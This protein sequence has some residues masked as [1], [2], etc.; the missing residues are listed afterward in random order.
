MNETK[1]INNMKDID[2]KMPDSETMRNITNESTAM[3][4]EILSKYI[5]NFSQADIAAA[6]TF[7]MTCLI[8]AVDD[9]KKQYEM[10]D[11][12][13]LSTQKILDKINETKKY[14]D[15]EALEKIMGRVKDIKH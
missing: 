2:W 15:A 6:L 12:I 8:S 11:H 14:F 10:L 9:C 3:F 13:Y 5:P 7:S 4:L 1:Q